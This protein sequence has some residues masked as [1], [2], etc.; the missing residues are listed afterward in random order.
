MKLSLMDCFNYYSVDAIVFQKERDK[1]LAKKRE[2]LEKLE[3]NM[4]A[5]LKNLRNSSSKKSIDLM[6][7]LVDCTD[8]L[9]SFKISKAVYMMFLTFLKVCF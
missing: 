9:Q 6:R 4:S 8:E 7:E 3:K 2:L 5:V 1:I